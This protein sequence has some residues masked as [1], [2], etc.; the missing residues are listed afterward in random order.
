MPPHALAVVDTF[1]QD[2]RTL[3]GA[4]P[5]MGEPPLLLAA[6][7]GGADSMVLLDCLDQ[8]RAKHR[9]RLGAV[10]VHHGLRGW[11]ADQDAAF[12]KAECDNRGLPYYVVR[13]DTR[14]RMATSD[15]S[16]EEA[17]RQVRY[18]AFADT[19]RSAGARAVVVAHHLDD[20]VET[21]L[22]RLI[23]GGSLQALAGMEPVAERFGVEVWRPF[24][25]TS[26][27]ALVA[28]LRERGLK[29]RSD[30][31]NLE[32]GLLRNRIRLELLPRIKSDFNPQ[33]VRTLGKLLGELK[34][35]RTADIPDPVAT[36]A[37][38]LPSVHPAE[39]DAR[40]EAEVLEE[41][42]HVKGTPQEDQW[43]FPVVALQG[44]ETRERWGLWKGV[45]RGLGVS[46]KYLTRELFEDL[47]T[48]ISR[49]HGTLAIDLP[50]GRIA[51]R[52]YGTLVI[53]P[54]LSPSPSAGEV[55][56][57]VRNWAWTDAY[58]GWVI[59]AEQVRL[60]EA[61]PGA[62]VLNPPPRWWEEAL[63]QTVVAIDRSAA[64]LRVRPRRSGDER[65][66]PTG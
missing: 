34:A 23:T 47:D 6:V 62:T 65:A 63:F 26:Q 22:M 9:F 41:A 2:P 61:E 39:L 17:A 18:S 36:P 46:P 15:L 29:F 52:T 12:V 4:R 66:L 14:H 58:P 7:S 43:Q 40:I 33:V 27:A 19:A 54:R 51:R 24:L 45:L 49:T 20:D 56:L 3:G 64:E 44:L 1:L 57:P 28:H 32:T 30:L 53:G 37:E 10:H 21:L 8:L 31:S 35:L 59:L 42:A 60:E 55:V 38:G 16:V 50:G 11:D 25:R 5:A 48:L 13:G